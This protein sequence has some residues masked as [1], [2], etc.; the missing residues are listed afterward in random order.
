MNI[1]DQLYLRPINMNILQTVYSTENTSDSSTVTVE[2]TFNNNL[3]LTFYNCVS[4]LLDLTIPYR[5]LMEKNINQ[6]WLCLYK[7]ETNDL[8]NHLQSNH[9]KIGQII[10][11]LCTSIMKNL[12]ELQ[13]HLSNVHLQMK[14]MLS[15]SPKYSMDMVK[16]PSLTTET[17]YKCLK[18][19]STF[20]GKMQWLQHVLH[21]HLPLFTNKCLC[22]L[23]TINK[24][25]KLIWH[26]TQ[27]H[28]QD[29][30]T[31]K[32][33]EIDPTIHLTNHSATSYTTKTDVKLPKK[34]ATFHRQQKER[35][36]MEKP[37][38]GFSNHVVGDKIVNDQKSSE[39]QEVMFVGSERTIKMDSDIEKYVQQLVNTIY[40]K[41]NEVEQTKSVNVTQHKPSSRTISKRLRTQTLRPK[42][43]TVPT[44]NRQKTIIPLTNNGSSIK[45]SIQNNLPNPLLD[46]IVNQIVNN[47][48]T[49]TNKKEIENREQAI[50]TVSTIQ[51][52]SSTTSNELCNLFSYVCPICY[53]AFEQS[54]YLRTHFFNYHQIQNPFVCQYD[55]CLSLNNIGNDYL[56]HLC[57]YH[58]DNSLLLSILL[59]YRLK[60]LINGYLCKL[61]NSY[62]RIMKTI[63]DKQTKNEL[64]LMLM[65]NFNGVNSDSYFY[66]TNVSDLNSLC[67]KIDA[68]IVYRK[69]FAKIPL[70]LTD[71]QLK[72]QTNLNYYQ[73]KLCSSIFRLYSSCQE[74]IKNIH[75]FSK[76]QTCLHCHELV[77]TTNNNN[78]KYRQHLITCPTLTPANNINT[79]IREMKMDEVITSNPGSITSCDIETDK[80]SS[81]SHVEKS[82]LVSV[83]KTFSVDKQK[84]QDQETN[85][86]NKKRC[87]NRKISLSN[88]KHKQSSNLTTLKVVEDVDYPPPALQRISLDQIC[89]KLVKGMD[90]THEQCINASYL[91]KQLVIHDKP[92]TRLNYYT[93]TDCVTTFPDILTALNHLL[94]FHLPKCCLCS[95]C[96]TKFGHIEIQS[97]LILDHLIVCETN[98]HINI[99]FIKLMNAKLTEQKQDDQT[100]QLS[101]T[102]LIH[103]NR[104]NQQVLPMSINQSLNNTSNSSSGIISN[105]T[106]PQ[107]LTIQSNDVNKKQQQ[108]EQL[109]CVVD[110]DVTCSLCFMKFPTNVDFQTHITKT[111]LIYNCTLCPK[112][113]GEYEQFIGSTS[114]HEHLISFHLSQSTPF[115]RCYLCSIK[116]ESFSSLCLHLQKNCLSQCQHCDLCQQ[117][118]QISYSTPIDLFQHIIQEHQN[119]IQLYLQCPLCLIDV[120]KD[121]LNDHFEQET[122]LRKIKTEPIEYP[123]TTLDTSIKVY[124]TLCKQILILSN[125]DDIQAHSCTSE[126][127]FTNTG[128]MNELII[129][130]VY[131]LTN[132]SFMSSDTSEDSASLPQTF[133]LSLIPSMGCSR[134]ITFVENETV[135]AN[136]VNKE[137]APIINHVP[138]LDKEIS[139]ESKIIVEE[140][141]TVLKQKTQL[142]LSSSLNGRI[143]SRYGRIRKQ[144]SR[145][146]SPPALVRHNNVKRLTKNNIDREQQQL[147]P[148]PVAAI[149]SKQLTEKLLKKRDSVTTIITNDRAKLAC[150]TLIIRT[151]SRQTS[152]T[153]TAST[154]SAVPLTKTQFVTDENQK[155]LF[156]EKSSL[157]SMLPSCNN[158]NINNNIFNNVSCTNIQPSP[159]SI[160]PVLLKLM[161]PSHSQQFST[162]PTIT[163]ITPTLNNNA[164]INLLQSSAN[165]ILSKTIATSLLLNMNT[166]IID[167]SQQQQQQQQQQQ[168]VTNNGLV[169]QLPPSFFQN[170]QT[171]GLELKL[172]LPTNNNN[173]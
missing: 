134:D 47:I 52:L 64:E 37:Q 71:D 32:W 155:R 135:T 138:D 55:S 61:D 129:D 45:K 173:S 9:F 27:T 150:Q 77:K 53:K 58:S 158:I 160:N 156:D 102:L 139:T 170:V 167:T 161:T 5:L 94:L 8:E 104:K 2:F 116:F 163:A 113:G 33:A 80:R 162:S 16:S 147:P 54:Y 59:S 26:I 107:S 57:N 7:S 108:K 56:Q 119:I 151:A 145:Q 63:G 98:N 34:K 159:S 48:I 157:L 143:V 168:N 131:S 41:T 92:L 140:K 23:Q 19:T 118:S 87:S 97:G 10:C 21:Q 137:S 88:K 78:D 91:L 148:P 136:Q 73:C 84:T 82:T 146:Q 106:A 25:G 3:S 13:T 141:N 76:C 67:Q 14:K 74:H 172:L 86:N 39:Y 123:S 96:L 110:S 171:N 18:C 6:C 38:N 4:N 69:Y 95:K 79:N 124:C 133:S 126:Q 44:T 17:L 11:P 169:L 105:D 152:R 85:I 15:I 24:I 43:N 83:N 50:S 60:E 154:S 28:E 40:A 75:T 132:E 93:C 72:H 31:Q 128:S 115:Y 12:I 29:E 36:V 121:N 51:S 35:S 127:L 81:E 166:G 100:P 142:D 49:I 30:F 70:S 68:R 65:Q 112:P 89:S 114:Y 90:I 120:N 99:S 153:S 22:C 1:N 165:D 20:S 46:N 42:L 62:N 122:C 149:K 109:I 125:M 101:T 117:P 66:H 144:T 164:L 130:S 111:H 103:Q